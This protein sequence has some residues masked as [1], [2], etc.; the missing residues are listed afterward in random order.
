MSSAE[1]PHTSLRFMKVPL[2]AG[3][4]TFIFLD[5]PERLR[6]G[7]EQEVGDACDISNR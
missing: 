6:E 5:E 2:A 1:D 3:E 4:L 7:G